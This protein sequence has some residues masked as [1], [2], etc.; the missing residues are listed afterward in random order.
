MRPFVRNLLQSASVRSFSDCNITK[1]PATVDHAGIKATISPE[2]S[3]YEEHTEMIHADTSLE[4]TTLDEQY[5]ETWS[6][7]RRRKRREKGARQRERKRLSNNLEQVDIVGS[8]E[9]DEEDGED[10]GVLLEGYTLLGSQDTAGVENG[11]GAES[12]IEADDEIDP[13]EI[14]EAAN[15][16]EISHVVSEVTE[17][18]QNHEEGTT[19]EMHRP[20]AHASNDKTQRNECD[21]RTLE[22]Q[23]KQTDSFHAARSHS[24]TTTPITSQ[25]CPKYG[26]GPIIEMPPS[27]QHRFIV[28]GLGPPTT[29]RCAMQMTCP[30][31]PESLARLQDA[32][33]ADSFRAGHMSASAHRVLADRLWR[34]I[35]Y[36]NYFSDSIPADIE[37]PQDFQSMSLEQ[38]RFGVLVQESKLIGTS[39]PL[40]S[41]QA[42]IENAV[43]HFLTRTKQDSALLMNEFTRAN[44]D[45]ALRLHVRLVEELVMTRHELYKMFID[46]YGRRDKGG[47]R[48]SV[49]FTG[50]E[51]LFD[52]GGSM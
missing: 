4:N 15:G 46:S 28:D 24:S 8:S 18:S 34:T 47:M 40:P 36:A 31:F 19:T 49:V 29:Q 39:R 48:C 10:Q 50:L 21:D 43:L 6:E 2:F 22:S 13:H 1:D 3:T 52:K 32:D 16:G 30:E 17:D 9:D 25:F 33:L 41:Y 27:S 11:Q 45:M 7:K 5:T 23:V 38:Q 35:I 12:Q 44:R 42:A 51:V 20:S 26:L 37:L 14:E